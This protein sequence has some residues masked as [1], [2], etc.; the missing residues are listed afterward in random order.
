MLPEPRPE[1]WLFGIEPYL[2]DGI[3]G[4]RYFAAPTDAEINRLLTEA[5]VF[6]QTSTHEGFCLPVLE[7]MA[8]GCPVV[9]T[10]ADGNMD[11]CV[12]ERNA[13]CPRPILGWWPMRS[14]ACCP[15]PRC[16]P[17]SSKLGS[18]PPRT[19]AGRRGSMPSSNSWTTSRRPAG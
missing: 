5:T 12:H 7:A 9:S 2:A 10:G 3:P 18:K 14:A 17:R 19:T 13:W 6:V 16:V 11:F 1:L 15:T 4:M 8:T